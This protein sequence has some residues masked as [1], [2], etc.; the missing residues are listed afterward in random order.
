MPHLR[1]PSF[2]HGFVAFVWGLVLGAFIWGGLLSVGV[3]K[4]TSFIIGAVAGA[5]IFLYVR[6]YGAEGPHSS[7]GKRGQRV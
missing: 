6:V 4:A 1:P 2:A 7:S 3:S 5:G